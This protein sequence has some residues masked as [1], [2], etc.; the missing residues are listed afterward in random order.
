MKQKI[1]DVRFKNLKGILLNKKYQDLP[2]ERKIKVQYKHQY[3]CNLQL[4]QFKETK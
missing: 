1:V 4:L 2:N 3:K